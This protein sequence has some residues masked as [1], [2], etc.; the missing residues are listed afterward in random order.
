VVCWSCVDLFDGALRGD[1]PWGVRGYLEGVSLWHGDCTVGV[2]I[3]E[4]PMPAKRTTHRS[5]AGRKLYAK[6]DAKGRITDSQ[7]YK[8]AH[9]QDVK[10]RAKAEAKKKG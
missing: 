5:S 10:R 9:G 6:R 2:S 3:K 8:R 1:E 7:K 4:T